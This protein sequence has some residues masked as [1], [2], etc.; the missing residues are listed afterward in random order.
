QPAHP[1]AARRP[2]P[3]GTAPGD[4]PPV[5]PALTRPHDDPSIPPWPGFD[6]ERIVRE[7]RA[8]S[9]VVVPVLLVLFVFAVMRTL[10]S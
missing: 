6:P 7:I 5:V 8:A 4:R 2:P 9:F 1:H 10:G 3:G